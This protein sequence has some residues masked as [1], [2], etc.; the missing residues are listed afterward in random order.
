M[1]SKSFG[2]V[3]WENED[4]RCSVVSL[5][6]IYKSDDEETLVVGKKYTVKYGLENYEAV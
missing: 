5:N 1:N 2:I 3:L 4:D 6:E